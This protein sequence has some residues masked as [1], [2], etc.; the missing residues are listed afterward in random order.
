MS[1]KIVKERVDGDDDS[2]GNG[3]PSPMDGDDG[4]RTSAEVESGSHDAPPASAP[5]S[6]STQHV[7]EGGED[8]GSG[9][10][11]GSKGDL[12]GRFLS[13]RGGM[14]GDG[15]EDERERDSGGKGTGA[16]SPGDC[17]RDAAAEG[18]GD[19][20]PPP[21]PEAC[22]KMTSKE[23][24]RY[25]TMARI[26]GRAGHDEPFECR[27]VSLDLPPVG[28]ERPELAEL[29]IE[30]AD[31]PF[32]PMPQLK[33][34]A[35]GS[36]ILREVPEEWFRSTLWDASVPTTGEGVCVASV[37][38]ER[39]MAFWPRNAA[40]CEDWISRQ[41]QPRK[42]TK[43]E[44]LLVR[45]SEVEVS[46]SGGRVCRLVTLWMPP[47]TDQRLGIIVRDSHAYGVPKVD[48]VQ[49]DSPVLKCIPEEF[50]NS[51]YL[52]AAAGSAKTGYVT[53]RTVR[54]FVRLVNNSRQIVATPARAPCHA[55][56]VVRVR[57]DLLLVN[58]RQS[59]AV[60]RPARPAIQLG[61]SALP[62][63]Q[64]DG[65]SFLFKEWQRG[66]A[67]LVEYKRQH[68]HF[69]VDPTEYSPLA[70][71]VQAQR[72]LRMF[73]MLAP[74]KVEQLD[75]TGFF[76]VEEEMSN[77]SGGDSKEDIIRTP[78]WEESYE[79]LLQ[80]KGR[81]GVLPESGSLHDWLE[82]QREG[83]DSL[84][85]DRIVKL[86]VLGADLGLPQKML[87]ELG[88]SVNDECGRSG[89]ESS[90]YLRPW[91][92][93]SGAEPS[94]SER[95]EPNIDIDE[96]AECVINNMKSKLS[97]ET[98]LPKRKVQRLVQQILAKSLA[99]SS[100][101]SGNKRALIVSEN[102]ELTN[103]PPAK[104]TKCEEIPEAGAPTKGYNFKRRMEA[105]KVLA[106]KFNTDGNDIDEI[107]WV[108]TEEDTS[109]RWAEDA[110]NL[111][112]MLLA[113]TKANPE[114]AAK[115]V[116]TV[117]KKNDPFKEKLM[118]LIETMVN[119]GK[120][121]DDKDLILFGIKASIAHHSHGK[122]TRVA[123]GEMFVKTVVTAC[124]FAIVKYRVEVADTRLVK[125]IGTPSHQ[126]KEARA[127]VQEMLENNTQGSEKKR[128]HSR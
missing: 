81:A 102:G 39:S 103:A 113:I 104:R 125:L 124:L 89:K 19:Y 14:G 99:M 10:E 101:S 24:A 68:G 96:L 111:R 73:N 33:R 87:G 57:L 67:A 80:F 45:T 34:L 55:H 91:K 100:Q 49:P 12:I 90:D 117:L 120:E 20:R 98:K 54:D 21:R 27:A 38:S 118:P 71:W 122:G 95:T 83:I 13:R 92:G 70:S 74:A 114:R 115:A 105:A 77:G 3:A 5:G 119:A 66:L 60:R 76:W 127:R 106:P 63:P 107:A 75:K 8:D 48:S 65:R 50:R 93:Q 59:A 61:S 84:A 53:P 17:P 116:R 15:E 6:E 4:S 36:P 35:P 123:S 7:G 62:R 28:G 97:A 44:V 108:P 46:G 51:G 82:I 26:V 110:K 121:E 31:H 126:I 52:I 16:P 58:P 109:S 56:R 37:E 72:R 88:V 22:P 32:L 78:S 29:G 43:V 30:L 11:E 9:D 85:P 40:E 41:A 86:I 1:F 128:S 64:D 2:D 47:G 23:R 79:S 42:T 18:A 112:A 94:K 69:R 25:L